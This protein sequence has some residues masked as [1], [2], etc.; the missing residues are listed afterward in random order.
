MLWK[1]AKDTFYEMNF[2]SIADEK[3]VFVEFP[4]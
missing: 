1:T 2:C 4:M 3:P